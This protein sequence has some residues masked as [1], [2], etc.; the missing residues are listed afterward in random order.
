MADVTETMRSFHVNRVSDNAIELK[1]ILPRDSPR[2]F[3]PPSI[4]SW[5]WK[6][7]Y[8]KIP[9]F[10]INLDIRDDRCDTHRVY[11]NMFVYCI[12]K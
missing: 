7:S 10:V 3:F 4:S 6:Q 1:P 5:L 8:R 12:F 11:Y 2:T 9:A